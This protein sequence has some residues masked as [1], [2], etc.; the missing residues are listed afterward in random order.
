MTSRRK[1]AMTKSTELQFT[2]SETELN[3]KKLKEAVRYYLAGKQWHVASKAMNFAEHYHTGTRKDGKTPEFDH[4][5]RI[6][7]FVRTLPDLMHPEETLATVFLH[8]VEEDYD[9]PPGEVGTLFGKQ[10][11]FSTDLVTKPDFKDKALNEQYLGVYFAQIGN[12]PIASIVK[13]GDRVHNLQTMI[14]TFGLEKQ[15]AYIDEVKIYFLPMLKHARR[16]FPEQE[17]AYMNIKH[18]LVSQIELIEAIHEA[19]GEKN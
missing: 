19:I 2:F 12:D 14:G 13:G 17:A 7:H 6:A 18:M 15:K 3:H 11:A 16:L 1:V 9:V 5:V 4:Q 10:I 8:D